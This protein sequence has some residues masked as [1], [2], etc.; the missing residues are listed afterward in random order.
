MAQP[1]ISTKVPS[2]AA[3]RRRFMFF[4]IA[5]AV[6]VLLAFEILPIFMGIDASLRRFIL[7]DLQHPFI[8]LKNY[9][10]VITDAQFY[11][12]V[13][14]NTFLFMF[15]SVSGG[16]LLGLG[17]AVLLNRKFRGQN[18]VRTVIVFP[19][20]VAPVVAA[21]MVAWIF[22]DQFGIVNVIMRA[23]GFEPVVWLVNRWSSMSIVILTDIW[24]WTPW[25]VLLILAALQN[26]P[27]EPHEAARIDGANEWQVFRS[28]TLPLLRPVL[29][30]AIVIRSIDA[31]RVFD[32]VWTIT[33]GE[34]GRMTEVFSIYSY[35]ESFVFL[36]FG[37]GAASSIIGALIIMVIGIVL[38]F[39]LYYL[40]EL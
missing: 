12:V 1:A 10:K 5:P 18:V 21:T 40:S 38:Y 20:M 8:G 32:V 22:N 15:A 39:G 11:G 31:F 7:T 3:A 30:V 34:P 23:L 19:M 9:I 36:D 29:L 37:V 16:L 33:R 25:Y 26:I 2:H 6:F 24:L 4:L 35:K 27:P 17:L 13:L 14:F 28:V